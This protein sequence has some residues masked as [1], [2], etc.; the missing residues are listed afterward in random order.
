MNVTKEENGTWTARVYYRDYDGDQRRKTKR[1]FET[2]AEAEEWCERFAQENAGVVD[3][4]V[5]KFF[6]TYKADVAPRIRLN[7]WLT[8][9]SIVEKRIMPWFGAM[10][11]NEI[12]PID[13][14]RWQNSLM[15]YKQAN[16]KSFSATYLRTVNN[17]LSAI[18]NHAVRFYGLPKNPCAATTRMGS[19]K[20]PEMKFWT[21]DQY[22]EFADAIA[23][24]PQAFYAFELLYWCGIREG[25]LLALTPADFDLQNARL[26]ITK[27]Y[28]RIKGED[29]VT[30]PKTPK[31][32]RSILMPKFLVEEMSEYLDE[33]HIG[34]NERVFPV[35][36]YFLAHEMRRGSDAAGLEHIR[37][38]DLRHSHIS[39][40]I[41]MG[42]SA[43]AIADRMGHESADIT[44][45]Y[46]HLFPSAQ[47]DMADQ[48]E[49]ARRGRTMSAKNLDRHG[50]LR[51]K[52]VA[53]RMSE[54]EAKHLD[55]LVA[56]FGMNKQDYI[57][58]K[59]LDREVV[60]KPSS[61]VQKALRMQLEDV[62][63]ELSRLTRIDEAEPEK[64]E[65]AEHLIEVCESLTGRSISQVGTLERDI[66][67]MGR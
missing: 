56:V 65:M 34:D 29:V 3:V 44:F 38:H 62:A 20:G 17:Q 58:S 11:M 6:E 33:L 16:G 40:L 32:K 54:Q 60:V 64:L 27:S 57:I 48:L 35:T 1:G 28:Q 31:S 18:F 2:E 21:K 42:F 43:V 51:S 5:E 66:F 25:E 63:R 53:F 39:L 26:N 67:N 13:V 55:D 30:D 4:T 23:D 24:K 19:Q 8:K 22:L 10:R 41:D 47:N 45:R 46:A 7:T 9:E 15:G 61:R 36:K 52:V 37:V 59:L 14:V 49:K 12:K 50:R